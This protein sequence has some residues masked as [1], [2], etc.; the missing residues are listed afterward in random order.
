MR[1]RPVLGAK[2]QIV[3]AHEDLNKAHRRIMG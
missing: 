2:I 3:H 1:L